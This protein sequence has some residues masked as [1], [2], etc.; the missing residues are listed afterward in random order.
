MRV[1]RYAGPAAVVWAWVVI[2]ISS[3][4]NPTFSVLHSPLST[5]GSPGAIAPWIYNAGMMSMGSFILLY[6]LFLGAVAANW[7]E[8]FASG[9]VG[10]AGIF[11]A[12]VRIYH[13]GTTPHD[14]IS[15]WFF[16]QFALGS[17]VWGVGELLRRSRSGVVFLLLGVA[18]P[19]VAH[20]VPWPSN[21]LEEC[22]GA[23]AIDAF[24]LLTFW[25]HRL[26]AGV[27]VG[28]HRDAGLR[29]TP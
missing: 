9:L 18:A 2:L 5:L 25:D 6:A 20:L 13:A 16:L 11:L 3:A 14:F 28:G 10:T 22:F 29:H 7:V 8:G 24:A 27:G 4:A 19:F 23:L 12:L 21:G 15:L 26:S 1:L 17:S